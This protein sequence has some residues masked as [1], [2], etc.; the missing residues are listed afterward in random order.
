MISCIDPEIVVGLLSLAGT[1]LGSVIGVLTANKLVKY[2][3]GRL[4]ENAK[5]I[6][7]LTE[8]LDAAERSVRYVYRRLDEINERIDKLES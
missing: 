3:L 2:R 4:E 6:C 5:S 8:R 1:L 7:G